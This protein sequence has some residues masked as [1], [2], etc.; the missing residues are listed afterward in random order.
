MFE[1]AC[2]KFNS[3]Y[4]DHIASYTDAINPSHSSHTDHGTTDLQEEELPTANDDDG[5]PTADHLHSTTINSHSVD[6]KNRHTIA[7]TDKTKQLSVS[8]NDKGI[9]IL[10]IGDAITHVVLLGILAALSI[11]GELAR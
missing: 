9:D 4:S 8:K 7:G 1:C 3:V 6:K 11:I 10:E 5:L 2:I